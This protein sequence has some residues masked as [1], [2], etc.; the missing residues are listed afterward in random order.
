MKWNWQQRD[1]PQF[2]YDN[3]QLNELETEFQHKSGIL[4]GTIKYVNE[5]DRNTFIVELISNEALKTSEIE[6][7]YLD[8]DSLQSSIRRNFGLETGNSKIPPA[9]QGIAEM[10]V[11]LYKS[12]NKPLTHQQLYSWHKMLTK[13]RLDLTDIGLY[14]THD[15]PM[16][17]V[18]G[19]IQNRRIHFDAPPSKDMTSQMN[20]FIQWF[21]KTEPR[22]ESPLSAL[23]RAGI[24]HL[25]FVCIHPFED[26]NG[27][28][29]RAISEK[30]LSQ[31]LG[32][33]TLIALAHSIEKDKKSY[34]NMLEQSN[35]DNEISDWL[36]YFSKTVIDA[37][38]YSQKL[39]DFLIDK[40]KLYD[41]LKDQLNQRQD[42]VINRLFRAGLDGFE[43]GLSAENYI[44]ITGASRA[45][46]TR[47]LQDLVDKGALI[48]TGK[49]KY[50]RYYLN[51]QS[52]HA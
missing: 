37:Q 17:V 39:I 31:C 9:E 4:I 41:R 7:E 30:S 49:R 1:W 27:R 50:T 51:L 44:S 21:N 38:T 29:G 40:A 52:V 15:E 20:Q 23:I 3:T 22:G 24:A 46:T 35:K 12:F 32:Q 19:N 14:R 48:K 13:G 45:T 18:S 25:Y 33:P 11:D 47:D 16:Q 6:G 42:K 34:Y 8:R 28:I 5:D 10:M 26:G 43:G 2:S 36:I